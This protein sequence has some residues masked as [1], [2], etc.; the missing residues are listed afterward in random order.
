MMK[1]ALHRTPVITERA[2]AD[3]AWSETAGVV[4]AMR[5]RIAV[6]EAFPGWVWDA[7]RR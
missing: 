4:G 7:S 2:A 6:L 3:A 5:E 1:S